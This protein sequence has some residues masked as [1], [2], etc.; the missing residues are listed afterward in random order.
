MGKTLTI[1]L[2]KKTCLSHTVPKT[3]I[4][5][6]SFSYQCLITTTSTIP[7]IREILNQAKHFLTTWLIACTQVEKW[8][9]SCPQTTFPVVSV[10]T[11]CIWRCTDQQNLMMRHW[12]WSRSTTPKSKTYQRLFDTR[13]SLTS[14]VERKWPRGRTGFLK[15]LS[16][17]TGQLWVGLAMNTQVVQGPLISFSSFL[18]FSA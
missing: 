11:K 2:S 13:L 6:S 8:F 9:L 7:S 17:K 12:F 18:K 15:A 1:I 10:R 4:G 14:P 16:L 3:T 5:Y